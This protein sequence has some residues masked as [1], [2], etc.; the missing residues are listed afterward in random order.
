MPSVA[1]S[2]AGPNHDGAPAAAPATARYP[3]TETPSVTCT[4]PARP[5]PPGESQATVTATAPTTPTA[6]N[7]RPAPLVARVSRFIGADRRNESGKKPEPNGNP[8]PPTIVRVDRLMGSDA[9]GKRMQRVSG[10]HHA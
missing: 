10:H 7:K 4:A 5:N 2:S 8:A 6:A 9:P 3:D 1:T